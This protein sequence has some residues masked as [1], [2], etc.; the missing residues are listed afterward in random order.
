MPEMGGRELASRLRAGRPHLKIVYMS[1]Y[2]AD[3][4][5]SEGVLDARE[6]FIAKPLDV[7]TLLQKVRAVLDTPAP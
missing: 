2:A 6:G 7:N 4:I 5:V 1:G 3:A